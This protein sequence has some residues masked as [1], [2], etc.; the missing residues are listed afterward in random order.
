MRRPVSA[1]TA[2][3]LATA[4]LALT[5]PAVAADASLFHPYTT[6]WPVSWAASVA[7]GDVTGDGLGDVVMT[8]TS[9]GPGAAG[10]FS[11]WVY[12]Q[13][14]DHTLDPRPAQ[15]RTGAPYS[16]SMALAV[17]DVDGDHRLDVVVATGSGVLVY[18]QT[19]SG[20]S[21]TPAVVDVPDGRDLDVADVTGDGVPDI[22]V[23]TGKG[24]RVW[25]QTPGGPS[26]GT[27]GELTSGSAAKDVETG[28]VTGDGKIDVVTAQGDSVS[29]YAQ[30]AGGFAPAVTYPSGVSPAGWVNGLAVGDTTGDGLAD[31]HVSVGGNSPSA[32]VVTRPQQLDGTLGAP[33]VRTS[34]DA[35]EAV[36]VADVTGEGHGDLVVTHGGWNTVGVY[37]A[38][39]APGTN[40]ETRFAAPYASHYSN[41]GLAV[42]DVTGDGRA[43]VVVA[44]YNNGLVL[45][46]GAAPGEDV[47]TPETTITSGPATTGSRTATFAFASSEAGTFECSMDSAAWSPCT[48]P[49]TYTGL[50]DGNHTFQTRATDGSWNT[51]TSPATRTMTVQAPAT[52]ITGGPTG[53]VRST[54]AT[55]TFAATAAVASYQ[56]AFDTTTFSA[57]TSPATYTG[58]V[59]GSGPHTFR[60]RAVTSEGVVGPWDSRSFS[61]APTADLAV[62]MAATP[63]PVKRGGTLT[64]ATTVR[65]TGGSTATGLVL[66]HSLPAGTTYAG[67]ASSDTRASCTAGTTVRCELPD[68]AAGAAWTLTV[69]ATVTVTKGTLDSRA[70]VSSTS[71]D[72]NAANDTASTLTRVG[73]GK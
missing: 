24:V 25:K 72:P 56:C 29:V 8:T 6:F 49:V 20:L 34:Y 18:R 10:D 44:D 26:T 46:R 19:A 1:L 65:D 21:P 64:W 30:T 43:D 69:R 73:N 33:V 42:G 4:P 55:F 71:W 59:P 36:K 9:A 66:S 41:D 68:L 48:S 67:L 27:L 70:V 23:S 58:L 11:V 2:T 40:P 35:P 32:W 39:Q 63:D 50:G 47:T 54:S 37:D 14:A 45:L 17:A 5:A 57:C 51:D 13:R 31:V 15:I 62:S 12:R 3:L 52:T 16:S 7:T 61:V 38:D 60:A 28:D 22:V 53:T